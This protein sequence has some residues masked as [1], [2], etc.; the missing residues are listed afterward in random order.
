MDR[1]SERIL[2]ELLPAEKE[3]TPAVRRVK[4][5][6][7]GPAHLDHWAPP[8]LLE[9]AAYL[10]KLARAGDGQAS[11]TLKEYPG[12]ATMLSFRSRD[13]EAELHEKFADIFHVLAGKAT[14]VTGGRIAGARTIGPGE[15]RGERIEGGSR[16]ELRAGD[17]AHVPAGLP[18][19]MLV[20]GEGAFTAFVVKIKESEE[21]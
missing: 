17:L 19:Q 11:E 2:K 12:H 16:Q 7:K 1:Y 15:T 13:G 4:S 14:L 8:I 9:R 5:H 6:S 20:A 18:H 21:L 3:I 10:R